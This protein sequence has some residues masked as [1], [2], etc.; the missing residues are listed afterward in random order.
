[1]PNS[2]EAVKHLQATTLSHLHSVD[3]TTPMQQLHEVL[4]ML[5]EVPTFARQT[6]TDFTHQTSAALALLG[7]R[8]R[9]LADAVEKL[10]AL[11]PASAPGA[12]AKFMPVHSVE[13]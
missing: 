13:I 9:Q 3:L 4:T 8:T 11:V 7:A 12:W 2:S 1:M 10:E 6:D 5:L